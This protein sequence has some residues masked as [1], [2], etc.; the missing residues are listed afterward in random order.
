MRLFFDT[1]I[2]LNAAFSEPG[3]PASEQCMILCNKS[4]HQG[5]IAWHTLSN[6]HY[7]A[8]SRSGSKARAFEIITD[9][10]QWAEVAE[11][12]KS[13]AQKALNYGMSDFEDALQLAPPKPVLRMCSSPA[14]P[15]TSKPA[16]S[17]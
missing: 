4:G 12:T 8:K 17:P 14:T 10:L 15:R 11:T 3:G 6:A 7:I 13:D 9:L 16:P 2:L 1:N 5:W